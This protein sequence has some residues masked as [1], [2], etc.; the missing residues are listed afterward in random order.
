MRVLDNIPRIEM[1]SMEVFVRDY[2]ARHEPVIITDL[3]AGQPI[4]E[5]D[6]SDAFCERFP[7]LRIGLTDEFF[8]LFIRSGMVKPP[9]G[10]DGG[11]TWSTVADYRRSLEI[12]PSD[13][14]MCSELE[15][16]TELAELLDVPEPCGINYDDQVGVKSMLFLGH[17]GRVAHLHFDGDHHHVLFHQVFGRKRVTLFPPQVSKRLSP[18]IHWSMVSM[19]E[20]SD[21]ERHRFMVYGE[22]W[23]TLLEPGETLY[24]PPLVWHHLDYTDFGLSINFRFAPS[25]RLGF[26][27]DLIP[28]IY[29]QNVAAKLLRLDMS[30]EQTDVLDAA[31]ERL[32]NAVARGAGSPMAKYEA[33]EGELHDLYT[34]LCTDS[35]QGDYAASPAATIERN[36]QALLP[37]K[38]AYSTAARAT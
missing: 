21:E 35:V 26:L 13:S 32:R 25:R 27:A 6:S 1:P 5:I 19:E 10:M 29:L 20:M 22:A 23:D 12:D 17:A 4:A 30:G 15:T 37:E 7:K 28:E 3:F 8:P 31:E 36:L 2:M 24:M 18:C 34:A 9:R 11:Y 14:R 33:L 16:P 38:R